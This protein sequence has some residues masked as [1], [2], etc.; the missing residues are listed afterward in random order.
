MKPITQSE[1]DAIFQSWKLD[2]DTL[3]WAR[4]TN[5]GKLIGDP[6]GKTVRKSKHENVFLWMGKKQ[7]GFVLARIIWLLRTGDYPS[8]EVEHK[9][10]NPQNNSVSNLRLA[11]RSQNMANKEAK[12][13]WQ[14]KRSGKWHTQI[15]CE[16]VVH[17]KY[18]FDTPEAAQLYRNAKA[19]ELF[20]EYTRCQ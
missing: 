20:G 6:V 9:D 5:R 8:L 18:G 1:K 14:D 17:G 4:N 11:T 12:G 10:G 2:G 7:K 3:V 19:V 16:G 13:I 15:Q